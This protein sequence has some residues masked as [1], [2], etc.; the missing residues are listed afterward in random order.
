MSSF[1]VAI[2]GGNKKMTKKCIDHLGKEFNSVGEMCEYHNIP[3][4]TFDDRIEKGCSLQEALTKNKKYKDHLGN[5]F[6]SMIAMCEFHNVLRRT[7]DNRIQNGCSLQ[8]ALTK[9]AVGNERKCKDHLGNEFDSMIAMCDFYGI[10]PGTYKKR[11]RHNWPQLEALTL[12]KNEKDPFP[13]EANI[14]FK[15][16]KELCSFL[17]AS[18]RTIRR[19][20]NKGRSLKEMI[21]GKI[22]LDET[23][24]DIVYKKGII[25]GAYYNNKVVYVGKTSQGLE[26]RKKQHLRDCKK[27]N[28][29][30]HIF[31]KKHENK[32]FF[33]EIE[34]H[35]NISY[36]ELNALEIK[37]IA[38]YDTFFHGYNSTKGGENGHISRIFVDKKLQE[39]ILELAKSNKSVCAIAKECSFYNKRVIKDFLLKNNVV[40]KTRK[41]PSLTELCNV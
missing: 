1:F 4:S 6:D 40:I 14:D 21:D 41:H 2:K 36:E 39:K 3:R 33:K 29:K 9:K 38:Y 13:K 17:N 15:N 19:N 34:S 35:N 22:V 25:Y 26:T 23:V 5:E 12:P 30:F 24:K 32:V 28:T 20:L 31:L 18:Y 37:W 16:I 10:S 8:E 27:D 7:F 11:I